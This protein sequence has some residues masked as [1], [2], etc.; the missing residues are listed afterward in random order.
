VE[1]SGRY[2][3][4]KGD[5]VLI[6]PEHLGLVQPAGDGFDVPHWSPPLRA[7]GRSPRVGG[8]TGVLFPMISPTGTHGFNLPDPQSPFDVP[9][10]ILNTLGRYVA[11]DGEVLQ[12]EACAL[13]YSCAWIPP[14][15]GQ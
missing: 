11:T 2:R 6:D 5:P 8:V 15:P 10:L 12:F 9:S 1:A 13:D 14:M 3:D 4:A 7:Y